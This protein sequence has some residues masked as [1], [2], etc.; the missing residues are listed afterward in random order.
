MTLLDRKAMKAKRTMKARSKERVKTVQA[1]RRRKRRKKLTQ[2]VDDLR[3][4]SASATP[5][6]G[7]PDLT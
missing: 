1:K 6:W 5:T 7:Q 4:G 3:Y 2:A